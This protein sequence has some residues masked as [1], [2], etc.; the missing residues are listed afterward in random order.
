M[1]L[2][3]FLPLLLLAAAV[4]YVGPPLRQYAAARGAIPPGVTLGGAAIAT[5]TTAEAA[6]QLRDL[7]ESPVLVF[8]GQRRILLRPAEIDYRVAAEEMVAAAQERGQG[9][10]FARDFLFH[11]LGRPPLGGDIP[12]QY[13]YDRAKLGAWLQAQADAYDNDP[14]P[15]YAKLDTLTFVPGL[16]GRYTNLNESAIAIL[17]AFTSFNDRTAALALVETPAL[18]PDPTTLEA[19]FRQRLERFPGIYSLY[20]QDLHSGAAIDIDGDTPF[21]GMSTVKIPILLKLYHDYELPLSPTLSNWISDTVQSE[22]ASNAA[23]NALMYH[24]GGGDTLSGARRV[25]EFMRELGFENTF[26]AIP[27]DSD[28]RPPAVRT[29]ANVNPQYNTFPDPAMQTTPRDIGELLAE[30]GQC[31][32]GRGNLIAAYP[33]RIR[34][35]ECQELVGW[36]EQNPMGYLIKYGVPKDARIGHKHGYAADSQGDVAIIYGP[37]GPYILSIFVYQYG[38]VVWEYSNPLMNDLSRLAWNYYLARAGQEQLP[39][40]ADD[41]AP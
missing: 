12:L 1:K 27:Y 11:L 19:A 28:L 18:P 35:E 30:I 21:A 2:L 33:G 10:A 22:I 20:F 25:T 17:R 24:I 14:A 37:E 15:A 13:S 41:P 36:L 38:W 40:F 3:R 39:P 29:P 5:E 9:L 23:A 8:H 16:P 31:A 6:A 26:I 7:F 32:E 34:A 4:I